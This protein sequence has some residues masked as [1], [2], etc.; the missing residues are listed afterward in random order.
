[1]NAPE[2]AGEIHSLLLIALI[3][4]SMRR[5]PPDRTLHRNVLNFL[6]YLLDKLRAGLDCLSPAFETEPVRVATAELKTVQIVRRN[7]RDLPILIV[8]DLSKSDANFGFVS[9][10]YN[11]AS[12]LGVAVLVMTRDKAWANEMIED[13]NCGVNVVPMMTIIRNPKERGDYSRFSEVPNFVWG[14]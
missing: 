11:E 4:K 13:V 1:M 12:R 8:D 10:L 9:S 3:P 14:L 2:A 5:I 6:P 7:C